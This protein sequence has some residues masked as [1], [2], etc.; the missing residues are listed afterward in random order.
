MNPFAWIFLLM[1]IMVLAELAIVAR[2]DTQ[3]IPWREIVFNL[4]SG[5]VL[6]WVV[7]GVEIA[8]YG[9]TL[10][11]LSL[12]WMDHL[13]NWS[14]WI[15]AWIGW[16]LCFYWMHRM[17]HRVPL[18]WQ[19]HRI[20]HEGAHFSL[21]LAIRNGWLSSLSNFPFVAILAVVGV[22]LHVFVVVSTCHYAVQFYNHT[23]LVRRANWLDRWLVTPMNHRVHHAE[24]PIYR[25]RNF[26]GTLL[27]WDRWFAT[28][29]PPLASVPMHFGSAMSE[30]TYN[31]LWANTGS[32]LKRLIRKGRIA[33]PRG[34]G[35][36]A[37]VDIAFAGVVLF[38]AVIAFIAGQAQ[39]SLCQ[40]AVL[41]CWLAVASFVLGA[42][43]D[44]CRYAL[45]AWVLIC[46]GYPL[47][48]VVSGVSM[49]LAHLLLSLMMW[50]LAWRTLRQQ[51][52]GPENAH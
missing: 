21:S 36:M 7:R 31:P 4:N 1:L 34:T 41:V 6:L 23:A 37:D 45:L 26:G 38:L 50:V 12:R 22:P 43:S 11:H 30:P 25:D 35:S 46:I 33:A 52:G 40:N 49:D 17:H 13:P 42:V 10:T 29:Q 28:Y 20:H 39:A 2:I 32:L 15:L 5:H 18:L 24:A 44:G 3:P 16:D 19:V 47:V 14:V 8:L 51:M 48:L 27:C 9:W